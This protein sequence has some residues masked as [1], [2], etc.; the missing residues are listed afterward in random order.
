MKDVFQIISLNR[1]FRVEKLQEFLHELGCYV[2]LEGAHLDGF[3][4]DQLQ[5]E[6][7]DS[8]EVRPGGVHLFLLV[9]TSLRETEVGFLDV[10]KRSE[11]ILLDHLHDFVQVGN[12]DANHIF[13]VLKHLLE[14]LNGIESFSL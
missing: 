1:F 7:V 5:E 14:L 3:V 10:W 13:L 12:N 6:L 9:N 11:N 8:L 4:D 2:D